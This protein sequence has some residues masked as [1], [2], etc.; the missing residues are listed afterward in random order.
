[1]RVGSLERDQPTSSGATPCSGATAVR[2]TGQRGNHMRGDPGEGQGS[3][4]R[5]T[6]LE[7][8]K[9]RRATCP[10]GSKQ[11]VLWWR[12]F[13][14]SNALEV[15]RSFESFVLARCVSA[16]EK[17]QEGRRRRRRRTAAREGNAL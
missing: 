4:L 12:T 7:G 9:L 17:H 14:W 5:E 11:L 10:G 1:M 3:R 16:G 15:R 8:R 6:A 2:F 13:V